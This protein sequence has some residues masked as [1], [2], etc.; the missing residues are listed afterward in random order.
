MEFP[1]R[2]QLE[3]RTDALIVRSVGND[4]S[5][6]ILL[7]LISFDRPR[8]TNNNFCFM[9]AALVGDV[10]KLDCRRFIECM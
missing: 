6:K 10:M 1:F 7:L 8:R 4:I 3:Y 5:S 2:V 9:K